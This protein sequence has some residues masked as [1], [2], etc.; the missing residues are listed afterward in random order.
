VGQAQPGSG[1]YLIPQGGVA[2]GQDGSVELLSGAMI[3]YFVPQAGAAA[4]NLDTSTREFVESLRK[5]DTNLK[6]DPSQR[7]QVGG[8]SALRTKITTKMSLQQEPDQVVYLYTVPR[9]AGLWY[10]VLA[11]QPSNLGAF[12]PAAKQMVDS[13][14]FPD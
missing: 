5:G 10:L 4:T 7:V 2:K 6:A 12:D 14:Q 13:V 8:K 9:P 1:L 11:A 3:D